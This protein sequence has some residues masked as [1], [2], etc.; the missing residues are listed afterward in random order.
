MGNSQAPQQPC[1]AGYQVARVVEG[2]PA[3][4]AGLVPFFDF[5]LFVDNIRM[6]TVD[7][8]FFCKY[9]SKNEN[10]PL[11]MTLYSTKASTYRGITLVPNRHWGGSGLLGCSIEWGTTEQAMNCVWQ[12]MNVAPGSPGHQAGLQSYRDYLVGMQ[13]YSQES[14][15]TINMFVDPTD[16]HDRLACCLGLQ[17]QLGTALPLLVLVHDCVANDIREVLLHVIGPTL[18]LDIANGHLH[19]IPSTSSSG[20]LPIIR[21]GG[22]CRQPG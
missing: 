18:G 12:I 22:F 11:K 13:D 17:Q 16:V 6:D 5:I 3:H 19:H 15:A 10:Q 1:I 8:S 14:E 20:R 2:S 21:E 4:Q 9:I 7:S